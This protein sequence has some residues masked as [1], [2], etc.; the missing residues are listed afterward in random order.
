TVVTNGATAPSTNQVLTATSSTAANWQTPSGAPLAS[1]AFTGT[2]TVNG[3]SIVL[4]VAAPTG[5][6]ATDTTAIQNAINTTSSVGSAPLGSGGVTVVLQAGTYVVNGLT[7]LSQVR[8]LGQ[9]EDATVIQ[10]AAG[11]NVPVVISQN[12]SSLTGTDSNA[13]IYTYTFEKLTI[14]GNS[15]NQTAITTTAAQTGTGAGIC[16]YGYQPRFYNIEVRNCV[17]LGIYN[18]W[19]NTNNVSSI[20]LFNGS[21]EGRTR[22]LKLNRNLG[23]GVV[24]FGPSDSQWDEV[25]VMQN[26]PVQ[27]TTTIASGST[28]G[29]IANIASWSSP[30][31]G[32]LDVASSSSFATSGTATV[33]TSETS[34]VIAWT[35]KGTGTLTGCTLVSGAGTVS[36]GAQVTNTGTIGVWI[37]EYAFGTQISN[38]HIWG[39]NHSFGLRADVSIFTQNLEIEGASTSQLWIRSN[40]SVFIGG[41]LFEPGTDGAGFRI[42]DTSASV[43][44]GD[45]AFY[46]T[47][48][49]GAG[50]LFDKDAGANSFYLHV[51]LTSGTV[52]NGTPNY[53][54]ANTYKIDL[55]GGATMGTLY[56]GSGAALPQVLATNLPRVLDLSSNSA[57]PTFCTDDYDV[58]NVT[59]QTATITS[60]SSG[61]T[62]NPADGSRLRVS[63]TGTGSVGITWG[64]LFESS[65]ITLPTTTSSTSRLDMGFFW[66]SA[67]SKW[68][69]VGVA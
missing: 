18:E 37:G 24:W 44:A 6:A 23:G 68:R 33:V 66:N 19:G 40:G 15:S 59:A 67:T 22:G 64:S 57:T 51:Y 53:S 60:M 69:C 32:V 47:R 3:Q 2:P 41:E 38:M 12:F 34:A 49:N 7:M 48:L 11:A 26:G 63:I 54:K 13:G 58:V 39:Q 14:D 17:G 28:G 4:Q 35:G 27:V 50:M 5:V 8:L 1:P 20:T 29:N 36:T 21:M 42:G 55:N 10:L 25:E 43:G 65:T 31:A 45:N 30:S 61:V 16:C 9:G 56:G 62:G 52:F 46:G